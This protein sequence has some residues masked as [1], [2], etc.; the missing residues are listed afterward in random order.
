VKFAIITVID[1]KK[2]VIMASNGQFTSDKQP[3]EKPPRGKAR[4]T[5]ILEALQRAG[6][7]Q[8]G[9]YDLLITKA[10]DEDDSFAFTELWKRFHPIEK[11]TFPTYDFE[12]PTGENATKLSQAESIIKAISDGAI[13]IDAGKML[14]DIVK[15][16]STIEELEDHAARIEELE[17]LYEQSISKE[18]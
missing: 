8:E 12:L 11:A 9:F 13:P 18:D 1:G 16:A 7:S 17:K 14:M 10:I 15:D 4:R 6:H 2:T 3:G 5:L